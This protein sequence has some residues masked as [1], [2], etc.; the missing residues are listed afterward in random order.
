[1]KNHTK[2]TLMLAFAGISALANADDTHKNPAENQSFT[3][4]YTSYTYE[5][6]HSPINLIFWFPM[7]R[8]IYFQLLG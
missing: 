7:Y 6:E 3:W 4:R 8:K 2:L 5:E 1:M